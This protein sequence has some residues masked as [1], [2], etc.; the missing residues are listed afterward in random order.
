M[1]L[2]QLDYLTLAAI[3]L[4]YTGCALALWLAWAL[5]G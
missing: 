3:A 5:W 1:K 4:T 2:T